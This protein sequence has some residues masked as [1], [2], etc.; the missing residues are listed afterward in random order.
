MATYRNRSDEELIV[1]LGFSGPRV[2]AP[3]AT[4]E[5]PD[6]VAENYDLNDNFVRVDSAAVAPPAVAPVDPPASEA[7]VAP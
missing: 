5:V 4:I 1:G 7:P 6:E 3:D 2:V